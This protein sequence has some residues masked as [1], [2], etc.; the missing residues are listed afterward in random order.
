MRSFAT[1][2]ANGLKAEQVL[3]PIF[4]AFFN[5][6]FTKTDTYDPFDFISPTLNLELKSRTNK[7]RQY[8]TT[9]LPSS[10]LVAADRSPTETIFAFKF[11]DGLYYIKYDK[12]LFSSFPTNEFQRDDRSDH[13]DRRQTYTYIPIKYLRPIPTNAEPMA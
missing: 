12:T 6:T 11:T 1:D 8:P 9:L 2:Y 10:K 3:L 7:Y 13:T 4:N 5:T